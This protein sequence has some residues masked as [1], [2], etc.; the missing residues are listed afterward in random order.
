MFRNKVFKHLL[1]VWEQEKWN[2]KIFCI[3][4]NPSVSINLSTRWQTSKKEGKFV[5]HELV[6]VRGY[7]RGRV[8]RKQAETGWKPQFLAC[9][10]KENLLQ[11]T[12]SVNLRLPPSPQGEG[13][14]ISLCLWLTDFFDSLKGG[15]ASFF[16]RIGNCVILSR[17]TFVIFE[18]SWDAKWVK[19]HASFLPYR[20]LHNFIASNICHIWI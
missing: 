7:G 1:F 8:G 19:R 13:C 2:I 12:S 15:S 16:Y 18:F 6:G 5:Q 9:F 3:A 4:K 11:N 20:K 10:I 14:L 17:A